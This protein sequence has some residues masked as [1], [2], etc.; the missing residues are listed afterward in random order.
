MTREE[1]ENGNN[2]NW[3]SFNGNN[4]LLVS[5]GGVRQGLG[6]PVFEF[7]NS[8]EDLECDKIF[9]RD[10]NQ[11]W[12]QQGIDQEIDHVH[13]V[14]RYLQNVIEENNYSKTC[15]LGNSMGGYAAILFGCLLNVDAVISFAPQSFIDRYHR[16]IY[17]DKRWAKQIAS[18]YSN[19]NKTQKYFDLKRILSKNDNASPDITIYYSPEDSLDQVH[20]RRLAG[21]ANVTLEE[22]KEGGHAVVKTI[23]NSGRL[24]SIIETTFQS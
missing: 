11:S 17:R 24:H 2:G 9:L 3:H 20:A 4:N 8:I 18:V 14:T 21:F 6:V 23:R 5:F 7:F 12:Y 10:F 13:K 19:K 22:V 1:I 15:F 16:F